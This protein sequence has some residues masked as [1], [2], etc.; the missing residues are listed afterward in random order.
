M[1]DQI[2]SHHSTIKF[3][4]VQ[5]DEEADDLLSYTEVVDLKSDKKPVQNYKT[6]LRKKMI[7]RINNTN[8]EAKYIKELDQWQV[9]KL[10]TIWLVTINKR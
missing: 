7:K 2:K 3:K 10:N 5:G 8:E 1:V 4:S 6:I 9:Q